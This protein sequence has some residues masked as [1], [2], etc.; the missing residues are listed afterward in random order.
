MQRQPL[1]SKSVPSA[2]YDPAQQTLELEFEGG[3]IYR[4]EQV[5]ESVYAWL[6]RTRNKGAYVARMISPVYSYREVT[7]PPEPV[8][9]LA[10]LQASLAPPPADD[11]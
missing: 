7:P 5:P 11:E 6:L 4:Y 9:L 3:R 10:Q 2:G 1:Q 8:D